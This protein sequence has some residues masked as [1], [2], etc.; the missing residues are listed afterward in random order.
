M[1]QDIENILKLSKTTFQQCDHV[2]RSV[3]RH[4]T[5]YRYRRQDKTG[6]ATKTKND[7]NVNKY[8]ITIIYE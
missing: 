7:V 1:A 2:K 3:L 4:S 8:I 6:E 5:I